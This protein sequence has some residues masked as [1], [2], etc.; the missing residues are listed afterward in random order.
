MK[1]FLIFAISLTTT[2]AFGANGSCMWTAP[3]PNESVPNGT[4]KT[5]A[6]SGVTRTCTNG[7]WQPAPGNDPDFGGS[8]G[9]VSKLNQA[10]EIVPTGTNGQSKNTT[11]RRK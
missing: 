4:E 5:G 11:R 8:G 3:D 9:K 7:S 6:V 1:Y 2:Q 10:A